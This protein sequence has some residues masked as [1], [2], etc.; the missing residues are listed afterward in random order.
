LLDQLFHAILDE[1]DGVLLLGPY[2]A[3]F[4]RDLVVGRSKV[5]L[6]GVEC[7]LAEGAEDQWHGEGG[8]GELFEKAYQ[9]ARERGVHV[10]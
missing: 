5:N 10:S 9:D 1:Q 7:S 3:G 8:L 6:I 2:Y 4:D